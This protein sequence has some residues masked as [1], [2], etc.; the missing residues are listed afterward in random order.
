LLSSGVVHNGRLVIKRRWGRE[1]NGVNDGLGGF[2]GVGGV[3]LVDI[4]SDIVSRVFV[5]ADENTPAGRSVG[6][7][8]TDS[9]GHAPDNLSIM[10]DFNG[11]VGGD[12]GITPWIIRVEILLFRAPLAEHKS[13]HI[14]TDCSLSDVFTD[15]GGTT[16]LEHIVGSEIIGP[17]L[18][19]LSESS[20]PYERIDADFSSFDVVEI[21]KK[22]GGGIVGD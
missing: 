9:V 14:G 10:A 7:A 11:G 2:P 19:L 21:E 20:I 12:I 6:N 18:R 16:V 4:I 8:A 15:P 22:S 13:S 1:S 17:V 3:G 5:L